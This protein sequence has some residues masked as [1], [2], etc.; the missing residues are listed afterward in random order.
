LGTEGVTGRVPVTFPPPSRWPLLA[1][2]S[3]PLVLIGFGL[4]ACEGERADRRPPGAMGTGATTP[5]PRMEAQGSFFD[6]QVG[7]EVMLA[8]AGEKWSRDEPAAGGEG[9]GGRRRGGGH[10]GFSGGMGG[11]RG[12]YGGRGRGEGRGE[13]EAGGPGNQAPPIRAVNQPAV[14]LRLRLT[15]HGPAPVAVAV[16]DFNSTLGDFV[17]QPEQIAVKPGESVEADPMVSRLGVFGE[18]IPLT[19]KLHL[20]GRTEQQVL[21]LRAVPESRTPPAPPAA[22]SVAPPPPAASPPAPPAATGS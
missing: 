10:V 19:V 3:L 8:R 20:G 6:G 13:E 21:T 11:M 2:R 12:G 9:G 7:V 16:V 14:Q 22:A 4:A 1:R 17:V 15:D 5:I 18:E